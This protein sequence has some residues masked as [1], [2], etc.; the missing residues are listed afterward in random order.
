MA[1]GGESPESV[2]ELLPEPVVVVTEVGVGTDVIAHHGR[3][4]RLGRQLSVH[5]HDQTL[6]DVGGVELSLAVLALD[7]VLAQD[8]HGPGGLVHGA[9]D[10][11]D[12]GQA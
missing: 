11:L 2:P 9:D 6:L 12:N 1:R 4:L 3:Q 5:H 10:V 7:V 8:D